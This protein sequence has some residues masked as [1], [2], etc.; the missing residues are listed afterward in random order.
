M[1]HPM[2]QRTIHPPATQDAGLRTQGFL[3][4][5]PLLALCLAL[6]ACAMRP[7]PPVVVAGEGNPFAPVALRIHPL[8]HTSTQDGKPSIVAHVELR[9]AWG[10]PVKGVG[11]LQ[12]QLYR[13]TGTATST[14][15]TQELKW[16]I[17]LGN[18]ELNAALYDP[19]TRTYRLPLLEAPAWIEQTAGEGPRIRLRAVLT[20]A[21]AEGKQITIEDIY[22][23]D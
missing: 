22:E 15:G 11:V 1:T 13:P 23:I 16:D 19:A 20:T 4:F 10:D 8:T 5:L 7:K 18:L 14:L 9:D 21:D 12:V 6:P 3:L 17:D 2:H